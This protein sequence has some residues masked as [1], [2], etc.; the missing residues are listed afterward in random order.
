MKNYI[1]RQIV[2]FSCCSIIFSLKT[3]DCTACSVPESPDYQNKYQFT[4][5]VLTFTKYNGLEFRLSGPYL[6][7]PAPGSET[8]FAIA[9][10]L[11]NKSKDDITKLT[12]R[13]RLFDKSGKVISESLNN[14]GPITF[15]PQKGKTMPPEYTGVYE[16][17]CTKD[18]S[19]METFGK[20][21][22]DLV[23][24]EIA[25]K[26]IY[27]KPVFDPEWKTF[28]AFKGLEFRI[29]KP[30]RYLDALS[31]NTLFAIAI[32]FKNKSG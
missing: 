18:K 17:F 10:E 9:L 1:V 25:I 3:S 21:E 24:V 31:G 7:S 22:I 30:Y 32:E 26:D 16:R 6:S 23:E 29:S 14:C 27:D 8:N 13:V 11:N 12:F 2:F 5:P 19:I 20:I 4:N 15:M 28:P